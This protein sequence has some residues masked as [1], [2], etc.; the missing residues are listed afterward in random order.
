MSVTILL[1]SVNVPEVS[2]SAGAGSVSADGFHGPTVSSLP[3]STTSGGG[4]SLLQVEVA[5]STDSADGVR[6]SVLFTSCGSTPS[7]QAG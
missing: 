1:S 5:L 2:H 4:S 3:S 7:L 6:V